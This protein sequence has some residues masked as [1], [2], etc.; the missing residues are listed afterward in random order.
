METENL[1]KETSN[2]SFNSQPSLSQPSKTK[3]GLIAPIVVAAIVSALLA[4]FIFFSRMVSGSITDLA[5]KKP[6]PGIEVAITHG[7]KSTTDQNGNYQ[8]K[9]KG[10]KMFSSNL[11]VKTT[12]GYEPTQPIKI[13]RF[14]LKVRKDIILEPKPKTVASWILSAWYKISYNE[15]WEAM[16]PDD[17]KYW[18]NS[19]EY[20]D[21]LSERETKGR[22]LG[23]GPTK[24]CFI[25]GEVT[26]LD[27][28]QSPVSG[29]KYSNVAKVPNHC[30]ILNNNK[31]ETVDSFIY[32]QKIDG[33]YHFFTSMSKADIMDTIGF[34]DEVAESQFAAEGIQFDQ[35]KR[36]IAKIQAKIKDVSN[37]SQ[38]M[39]VTGINKIG[40]DEIV[41]GQS[42]TSKDI[43]GP[44]AWDFT[45]RAEIVEKD[46][47]VEKVNGAQ[48][49]RY[50]VGIKIIP[51][52]SKATEDEY[53][54]HKVIGIDPGELYAQAITYQPEY[55]YHTDPKKAAEIVFGE[56][57]RDQQWFINGKTLNVSIPEEIIMPIMY[58]VASGSSQE[59][60]IHYAMN[61]WSITGEIWVDEATFLVHKEK[62]TVERARFYFEPDVEKGKK[63]D[64]AYIF[65]NNFETVYSNFK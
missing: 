23:F 24:P 10:I 52:T 44:K 60:S 61:T 37:V 28:W 55:I 53:F 59:D 18:V 51:Y 38:F 54:I 56:Y 47:G 43:E 39:A 6:I 31:E 7:P 11:E 46:L 2:P 22:G 64:V 9:I 27:E 20:Q 65:Q 40:K 49:R 41:M 48:C 34:Y 63:T 26:M 17:K 57:G 1:S 5:S 32:M 45:K 50:K 62:Y 8:I 16:H 25:D 35:S 13:S 3:K 30:L 29:K 21:K 19:A 33:Y 14:A 4:F 42:T 15:T 58:V 12:D 36:I